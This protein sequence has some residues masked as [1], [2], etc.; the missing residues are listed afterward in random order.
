[1]E[2]AE[3]NNA[4]GGRVIIE[5]LEAKVKSL[6]NNLDNEIRTK[7]DYAKNWRRSDRK[8]KELEFQHEEECK[9]YERVQV[10]YTS[11]L[12]HKLTQFTLTT[13]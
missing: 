5:Q 3:A 1:M 7:N 9:N 11:L 8:L 4:R 13:R 12:I 6:V 2:E 10:R